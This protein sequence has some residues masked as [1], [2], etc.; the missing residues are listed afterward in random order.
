M[1]NQTSNAKR[2][3]KIPWSA[4]IYTLVWLALLAGAGYLILTVWG[5]ELPELHETYLDLAG[6][7]ADICTNIEQTCKQ[8]SSER[9]G[10]AI[11]ICATIKQQIVL[12]E[13]HRLTL[14]AFLLALFLPAIP[15][16]V[17]GIRK[18]HDD[19]KKTLWIIALYIILLLLVMSV[20]SVELW[21]RSY[22]I[23]FVPAAI[24]EWAFLGGMTAV[25]YRLAYQRTTPGTK[26]YAWVIAKPIIGIVMGGVVYFLAV[27]GATLLGNNVP[28][29]KNASEADTNRMLWLCAV[30]FIGGF[31]DRFSIQLINRIVSSATRDETEDAKEKPGEGAKP[32]ESSAE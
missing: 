7:S 29:T 12:T 27:A 19:Q 10:E 26:L 22:I 13:S 9:C 23:A 18:T 31:S 25:L 21:E 14:I 1:E 30:A 20:V 2:Q 28:L 6:A 17:N 11:K 3:I 32:T 15:L 16:A 8:S 24:L 5:V 4:L